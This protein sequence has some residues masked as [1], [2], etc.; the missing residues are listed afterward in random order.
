[1][2]VLLAYLG[3][4]PVRFVSGVQQLDLWIGGD[5]LAMDDL[6]PGASLRS[7]V[8]ASWRPDD[9]RAHLAAPA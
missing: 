8:V 7:K 1:M 9:H 6:R 5:I 3:A 4:E 2:V